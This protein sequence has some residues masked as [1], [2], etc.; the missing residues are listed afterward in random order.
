MKKLHFTLIELLVVI[1]IIAILAAMLLPALSKAR[2]KARSVNCLNNLKQ[3]SLSFTLYEGDYNDTLIYNV[4]W[5]SRWDRA[6]GSAY[7]NSYLS[8][9][10]NS[11]EVCCPGRPP[12][13][14]TSS[15]NGYMNRLLTDVPSGYSTSVLT[16][17]NASSTSNG[18]RDHFF[19]SGMVKAPS[20][21]FIVGDSYCSNQQK[22]FMVGRINVTSP[23]SGS[24]DPS[25][26]YAFFHNGICNYAFQDGHAAGVNSIPKA[27]ELFKKEYSYTNQSV[28]F[29]A[30][31]TE[32]SYHYVP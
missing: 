6:I 2:E 29:C 4:A 31:R 16:S 10:D 3:L 18:Y 22:Q 15:Y 28:H 1:A 8:A 32:A 19:F 25:T 9:G 27:A 23:V 26:L 11:P 12:F 7:G 14:F 13:K 30:W 24:N 21:F 17:Y 20:D 5:S